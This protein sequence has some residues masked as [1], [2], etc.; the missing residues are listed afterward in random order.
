MTDRLPLMDPSDWTD[1]QRAVVSSDARAVTIY[2]SLR[3]GK[4][5]ALMA[6]AIRCARDIDP[7]ETVYVFANTGTGAETRRSMIASHDAA[8]DIVVSTV[9]AI[10]AHILRRLGDDDWTLT[11]PE[12]DQARVGRILEAMGYNDL[13]ESPYDVWREL[14]VQAANGRDRTVP[15][16]FPLTDEALAEVRTRYD[17]TLDRT[18]TLDRARLVQRAV[19]HLERAGES[20]VRVSHILI[21]DAENLSPIEVLL[22]QALGPESVTA[23]VNPEACVMASL[24]ADSTAVIDWFDSI[25]DHDRVWLAAAKHTTP[26]LDAA[27]RLIEEESSSSDRA[28]SRGSDTLPEGRVEK[29]SAPSASAEQDRILGAMQERVEARDGGAV[30]VAVVAPNQSLRDEIADRCRDSDLAVEV[31]GRP[32]HG[33]ETILDVLSYLFVLANPHDDPHLF[34]VI[35]RPSR[36]IGRKTQA[37]LRE[38]AAGRDLSAWEAIDRARSEGALSS[39]ARRVL[40]A[41]RE[42]V[43]PLVQHA[44][45]ASPADVARAVLSDTEL[46]TPVTRGRTR[47][48]IEREERVEWFLQD[49]PASGDID[50]LRPFL[51]SIALGFSPTD[52]TA[53]IQIATLREVRDVTARLV[54]VFGL[55]E[56]RLPATHAVRRHAFIEQEKRRLAVAISR[57]ESNTVLSWAK[58]RGTGRRQEPTTRSRFWDLLDPVPTCDGS[59]ESGN[60][61]R[62]SLRTKQASSRASTRPTDED[63]AAIEAGRRVEHPKLGAGTVQDVKMD[64]EKHVATV[65]FDDRGT[66]T[67]NLRYAPLTLLDA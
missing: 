12:A 24:G 33:Q 16:S 39:R 9:T 23:A 61:Y 58:S 38:Y 49:L 1:G 63:A 64:G 8:A 2:G 35:N 51:D 13:S 36:G 48:Q 66:K 29:F 17:A 65:T 7:E 3:S 56:G 53:K 42:M 54:F 41:F 26:I 27:R 4:T 46:L 67:L 34:R 21:D 44:R 47:E 45:D 50:A 10:A 18:R 30:N 14:I 43:E 55:E 6:R 31:L 11:H 22:L 28:T 25:D 60:D 37:R 15:P 5:T 62:A 20:P 32:W 57:A 52:R 19:E 59:W 40:G